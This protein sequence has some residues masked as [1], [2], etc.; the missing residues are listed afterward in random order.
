MKNHPNYT[1]PYNPQDAKSKEELYHS[2]T[3]SKEEYE[4]MSNDDKR[5]FHGK[6]RDRYYRKGGEEDL[7]NFHGRMR[8]RLKRNSQLPAYYSIEEERNA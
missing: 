6:M 5:R 7:S 3:P 1:S 8:G 4:N 2:P